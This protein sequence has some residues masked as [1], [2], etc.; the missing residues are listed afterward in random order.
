MDSAAAGVA[1]I[2]GTAATVWYL[3]QRRSQ[4]PSACKVWLV[5]AGPGAADL[6]SVRGLNLL[7]RADVVV[8]DLLISLDLLQ[9]A[10]SD[11]QLINV[12]KSPTRKRFPQSEI[13]KILDSYK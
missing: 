11:A 13:N 3:R 2:V 4:R 8:H 12:G 9:Q 5:G 10:R 6:I 1:A 7:S